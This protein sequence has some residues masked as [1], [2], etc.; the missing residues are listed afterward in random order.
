M[1]AYR[2]KLRRDTV[3]NEIMQKISPF[4]DRESNTVDVKGFFKENPYY[5]NK[6]PYY[7]G[8]FQEFYEEID[9]RPEYVYVKK[10]KKITTNNRIRSLRNQL[11][12]ERLEQLRRANYTLEAIADEYGVSKQAIHQLI[13]VL[14]TEL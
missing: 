3:K 8:G 6:I 7:F 11:A 10:M 9:A 2:A 4:I 5:K 1:D 14:D 12:L 13:S